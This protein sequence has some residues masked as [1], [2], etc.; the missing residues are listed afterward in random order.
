MLPEEWGSKGKIAVN[1]T[2]KSEVADHNCT[3]YMW[4]NVGSGEANS[5]MLHPKLS[6]DLRLQFSA[7]YPI[8]VVVYGEDILNID[9]NGAVIYNIYDV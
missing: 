3:L 6:G 7:P 9:P 8:T 2:G 4:D 5:A 1:G